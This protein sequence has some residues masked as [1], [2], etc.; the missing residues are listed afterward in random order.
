M[1]KVL[2]LK[3]SVYDICVDD[4]TAKNILLS[5]GFTAVASPKAMG[6]MKSRTLAQITPIRGVK[7]DGVLQKFEE[8]GYVIE[9][10]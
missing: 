4:P 1:E 6:S 5:L 3:K 7:L 8:K 10:R 9:G 2:D